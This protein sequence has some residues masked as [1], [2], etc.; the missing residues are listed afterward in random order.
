MSDDVYFDYLNDI[1]E[2]YSEVS[3]FLYQ[4]FHFIDPEQRE[5][6]CKTVMPTYSQ[7]AM[8]KGDEPY[9]NKVLRSIAKQF[10]RSRR[11]AK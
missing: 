6:I 1:Y 5:K 3:E 7:W 2:I 9:K 11:V 10:K 4:K 8:I